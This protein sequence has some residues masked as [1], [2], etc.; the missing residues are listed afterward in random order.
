MKATVTTKPILVERLYE[1]KGI[2][3]PIVIDFKNETISLVEHKIDGQKTAK[4]KNWT[5]ANRGIEYMQ[6]WDDIFVAMRE[7][8][9]FAAI[10]LQQ[11]LDEQEKEKVELIAKA[12]EAINDDK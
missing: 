10:E 2:Q 7:C 12:H 4:T 1:H 8:V 6:G 9:K 11:Y 3:I 5:F